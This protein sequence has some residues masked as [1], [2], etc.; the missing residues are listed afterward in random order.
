MVLA[1]AFGG[2]VG[3]IPVE[4]VLPAANTFLE[5]AHWDE[6]FATAVHLQ[7]DLITGDYDIG[8]AGH[9]PAM[10]YQAGSGRWSA[11]TDALGPA[12][13]LVGEATYPRTQGRLGHGDALLVY[14][15]GVIESRQYGLADGI[16]WMLGRAEASM[17]LGFGGLVQ[18]LVAE[19]RAGA[20]DDRAAI[21]IWR[22]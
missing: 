20:S 3:S 13:G 10:T 15:D 22:E 21:I 19:G 7:V 2:M 17:S 12:L 5:R 16:D 6:G 11:V 8:H 9:P 1:G 14:T 4:D 18:R